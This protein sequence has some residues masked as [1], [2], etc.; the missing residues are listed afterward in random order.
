MRI[1]KLLKE[2]TINTN[3]ITYIER[4]IYGEAEKWSAK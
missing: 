2:I 4:T 1:V 3:Y